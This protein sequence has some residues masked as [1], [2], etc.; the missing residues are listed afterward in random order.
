MARKRRY[1]NRPKSRPTQRN[2]ESLS[3]R[4]HVKKKPT[5]DTKEVQ[6]TQMDQRTKMTKL[7]GV[8]L[9]GAGALWGMSQ[10][11]TKSPQ[12]PN[13]SVVQSGQVPPQPKGTDGLPGKY[14][15]E[16]I[17]SKDRV[18]FT[19]IQFD[20]PQSQ[21][22]E[23]LR[24]A[25]DYWKTVAHKALAT[26]SEDPRVA[27]LQKFMADN[28][29]YPMARGPRVTQFVAGPGEKMPDFK[30]NPHLFEVVFMPP[31]YAQTLRAPAVTEAGGH[32]VRLAETFQIQEW[33]G[34]IL[35]HELSHVWDM[36]VEKENSFDPKENLMGEVR[37]YKFERD[38]LKLWG[39]EQFEKMI[40][41]LEKAWAQNH[42]LQTAEI[43]DIADKYYPLKSIR[44]GE[45]GLAMFSITMCSALEIA[46]RKGA[47]DENLAEMYKSYARQN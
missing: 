13:V 35:A 20:P 32:T 24:S 23:S 19:P 38:L 14:D 46:E 42:K 15:Y 26:F 27:K 40:A 37:A 12:K 6:N 8:G 25:Q 21:D 28:A 34:I 43:V 18:D 29:V 31:V 11:A 2:T 1:N 39:P 10:V 9:L 3:A 45:K 17:P 44:G 7:L 47:T 4:K 30:N 22:F 41:E 33:L 5:P 36:N 16:L